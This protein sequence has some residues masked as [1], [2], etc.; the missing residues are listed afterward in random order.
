MLDSEWPVAKRA[1]AS[2]L[3]PENFDVQGRQIKKLEEWRAVIAGSTPGQDKL[4]ALELSHSTTMQP[5]LLGGLTE[6]IS[7]SNVFKESKDLEIG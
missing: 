1:F 6:T 2:W 5:H 3:A 7:V 4:E